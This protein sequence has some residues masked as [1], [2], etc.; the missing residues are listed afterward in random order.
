MTEQQ[1]ALESITVEDAANLLREQTLLCALEESDI[2]HGLL[3]L[4]CRGVDRPLLVN[5]VVSH[6]FERLS[7]LLTTEQDPNLLLNTQIA[8]YAHALRHWDVQ[9]IGFSLLMGNQ[10]TIMCEAKSG[11]RSAYIHRY[12]KQQ[13]S[14]TLLDSNP[15]KLPHNRGRFWPTEYLPLPTEVQPLADETAEV[16]GSMLQDVTNKIE[17][18]EP[19]PQSNP[20]FAR[21][22]HNGVVH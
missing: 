7:N 14:L 10:M 17:N 2:G 20:N 6:L 1:R 8:I 19:L 13:Q 3:Y 4:Y 9:Q 11:Q 16:M 22:N 15:L 21:S 18:Q 5:N 12:E